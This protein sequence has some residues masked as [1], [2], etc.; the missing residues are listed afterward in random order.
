MTDTYSSD[1]YSPRY[2]PENSFFLDDSRLFHRAGFAYGVVIAVTAAAADSRG[3]SFEVQQHDGRRAWLRVQIETDAIARLLFAPQPFTPPTASPML[4]SGDLPG[5]AFDLTESARCYTITWAGRRL[6]IGKAP[7][8]FSVFSADNAALFELET[9]QV[10]GDFVTPPLGLRLADHEDRPEL[11]PFLSWR[12]HND[13]QFF[14]LGEKFNKVEKSGTRATIWTWDTGGTNTTD[15]AYKSVPVLYS[16]RGWGLMLH[17]AYRSV[18]EVGNFSYTSGSTLSEAPTL[19]AFLFFGSTLKALIGVYTGL[20][21]R[22]HMPPL[23]AFGVWMSRCAYEN[24][25]EV[26]AVLGRL[27]REHIPCDVVHLD[28]KWMQ[29][30]YYPLIGVDACDFVWQKDAWPD[31]RQ[32]LANWRDQGFATCFWINPYLPEN[33][34]IYAE[35]ESNGY[36]AKSTKG[37]LARLALGEPVGIVDFT[38]PAAK[39][40]WKGKLRQLI[41]DGAAVFKPDYG[42]RVPEDALFFSGQT[43][44]ELHNLY[45]H[46]YAEAAFEAVQEARGE[47]IVWRRAGYIGSQRY[48][49]T[50]AGDTQVSWEAMRCCLR[51]GLSAGFTGEALW[52]HDIGGFVGP[53]PSEELYIRWAQWGLLSPFARFHGTTPREPWEYGDT[54][55]A[56]VRHYAQLR[57]SL[58]PYLQALA[59]ETTRS[60]LPLMRHMK[61]EFPDE[62]GTQTIDD[63]YMLGPDLLVAPIFQAGTRA[64]DVYIPAGTWL[65]WD[66]PDQRYEGGRYYRVPAPLEQIPV[67]VRAG[68]SIPCFSTIPDHLKGPLPTIRYRNFSSHPIAE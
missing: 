38:N 66:D 35:A 7:F 57:Y 13:E 25:A 43:G 47:S 54:A 46:L 4:V 29:T 37:G 41:D 65:H 18:W 20:T 50:W 62:P 59:E 56:V 68:A 48:A 17:T 24:R 32:M 58:I 40:W 19:D 27:R 51:G 12:I 64:R 28:P 36:L 49:G 52:S 30:H 21:G 9:E 22:L 63:Q 2:A 8:T 45:L 15:L 26:E 3:V 60:G 11:Q 1:S 39:A 5:A 6:E 53:K 16:T 23:W 14:G 33:S 31:H 61:L 10:A 44:C 42:D 67:F 55:L 34:P